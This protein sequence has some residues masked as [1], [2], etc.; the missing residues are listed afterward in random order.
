M[1]EIRIL[2][3]SLANRIAAGE[4]VERPASVVKELVENSL[5]AGARRVEVVLRDGGK[6]L[7]E[8]RDDG[9]GMTQEDAVLAVQ[10]FA[11]SKITEA[12]DLDAINTMGFRGEALP[13][14]G[15]VSQTKITTRRHDEAEGTALLIE[16]GEITDLRVVGCAPGT[17]VQVANLFYNTPARRKFLG[18]TA[19]ERGHCLDW[20]SR[21][22]LARPEVAYQVTHN[23]AVALNTPGARDLR[24]V[25]AVVY[26]SQTARQLLPVDLQVRGLR[27]SGFVSAPQVTRATRRHQLFFVNRRFVRSRMLSHALT[28]AYGMLLPAGK[29]PVAVVSLE[30]DPSQV[31]PNVHPTKIEVRFSNQGEIHSL[32]QQAVE[33]AL[34]E[35]GYR[36]L[37]QP[38]PPRAAREAELPTGRFAPPGFDEL[39]QV[40]RLRVN[41]LF[42]Q[43]DERDEGLEVH[44]APAGL[45]EAAAPQAAD[46]G[47]RALAA[48]EPTVLGQLSATYIVVQ[49]GKD[50]LL[51]DQHRAAERV[52]F[53]R[54]IAQPRRIARQLLAV[55]VTLELA[56]EE[57]AAVEDYRELLGEM[58]FE[59][60]QFGGGSYILR[61]V[62]AQLTHGN[63]QEIMQGIIAELAEWQS[64][65]EMMDR[66]EAMLATVSCHAAVK[67]GQ[68]LSAEEMQQLVA[69]LLQ[70]QTPATCPHGD[71]VIVTMDAG[72][73]SRKFHRS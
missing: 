42:D 7:I 62:P 61:S 32:V 68:R 35:A 33:A 45:A 54:L 37:T 52:I 64:S 24:S 11:T 72:Q 30:I 55:P 31:D 12:D 8:V 15:A 46:E 53:E 9:A 34:A 20:C 18:T 60:E 4:V 3:E 70:T 2:P 49:H 27:I 63:P 73:I 38:A 10:R 50:L 28:E 59:L 39:G 16:G 51:V 41:P 22:A 19:T 71:P 25:L 65:S 44:A 29:Q 36:S 56:P 58:G 66:R 23:D 69:D 13:S 6:K 47:A 1:A 67:A 14:I 5:D 57:A 40:K 21:L 48:E 43:V 17:T 26:G